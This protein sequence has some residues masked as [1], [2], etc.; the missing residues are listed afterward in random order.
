MYI[1]HWSL[2][3]FA[4]KIKS[5]VFQEL[6]DIVQLNWRRWRWRMMKPR[7]EMGNVPFP[8]FQRCFLSFRNRVMNRNNF[9][10]SCDQ[11]KTKS[12]LMRVMYEYTS[13]PSVN[14]RES[15]G[16]ENPRLC[17]LQD[18]LHP[19]SLC[20]KPFRTTNNVGL[21]YAWYADMMIKKKKLQPASEDNWAQ[22]NQHGN[23]GD[24]ITS[25]RF[26]YELWFTQFAQ[27]GLLMESVE[28]WSSLKIIN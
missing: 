4:V 19:V 15:H 28:T 7:N 17:L 6:F 23:E 14:T 2:K 26:I 9:F 10:F 20:T 3:H 18:L 12:F 16:R 25:D 11:H 24:M 13:C 5:R 1:I 27:I 8:T 22:N 21:I